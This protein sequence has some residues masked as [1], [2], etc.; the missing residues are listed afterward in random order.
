MEVDSKRKATTHY[1]KMNTLLF[2]TDY[3]MTTSMADV[4]MTT[5][6]MT[7]YN[8]YLIMASNMLNNTMVMAQEYRI[9]FTYMVNSFMENVTSILSRMERTNENWVILYIMTLFFAAFFI[10][11]FSNRRPIMVE[12]PENILE[13]AMIPQ[14]RNRYEEDQEYNSYGAHKMLRRSMKPRVF[15]MLA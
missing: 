14:K 6:N 7:A 5:K 4:M 3:V 2:I 13:D 12:V 15:Y 10:Q 1:H 9:P 8:D 11:Y